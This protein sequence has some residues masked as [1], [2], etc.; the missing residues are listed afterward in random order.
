[1]QRSCITNGII[2]AL[3][4]FFPNPFL[5]SNRQSKTEACIAGWLQGQN[6]VMHF[7]MAQRVANRLDTEIRV[8]SRKLPEQMTAGLR[9]RK[10]EVQICQLHSLPGPLSSRILPTLGDNSSHRETVA[11][12]S[13]RGA[14][15]CPGGTSLASLGL[16]PIWLVLRSLWV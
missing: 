13:Q 10:K 2:L 7:Y 16:V 6:S 15:L 3:L 4:Y 11:T 1:M 12:L 8:L 5:K 9:G 14:P